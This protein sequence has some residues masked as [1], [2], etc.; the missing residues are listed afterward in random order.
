[1]KTKEN[2]QWH[3][4]FPF[5]DTVRDRNGETHVRWTMLN[6][7]QNIRCTDHEEHERYTSGDE[8]TKIDNAH[9]DRDE[10]ILGNNE[11]D[12]ALLLAGM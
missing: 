1:M 10:T 9:H 6:H 5:Q 11:A 12:Q 2:D 4:Y 8:Q 7:V 3:E